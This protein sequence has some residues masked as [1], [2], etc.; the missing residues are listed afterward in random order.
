MAWVSFE[1]KICEVSDDYNTKQI[2]G[3]EK[4]IINDIEYNFIKKCLK[5]EY[6][7]EHEF[8]ELDDEVLRV[9]ND[10]EL[11]KRQG[12]IFKSKNELISH[13]R[14]NGDK[15][16]NEASNEYL[17]DESFEQGYLDIDYYNETGNYKLLSIK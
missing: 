6:G 3:K 2:K 4:M 16:Y 5:N 15:I 11:N 12:I 8:N 9:A 14:K 17:I 10:F 7:I 1:I 13:L